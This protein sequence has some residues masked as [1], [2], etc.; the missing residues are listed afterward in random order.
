MNNHPFQP[1]KNDPEW[2]EFCRCHQS[3]LE[4]VATAQRHPAFEGRRNN[5]VC[6][7]P[8][9]GATCLDRGVVSPCGNCQA[10]Q[11]LSAAQPPSAEVHSRELDEFL[12]SDA[13]EQVRATAQPP[14]AN[15]QSERLQAAADSVVAASFM[16]APSSDDVDLRL[17]LS[18]FIKAALITESAAAPDH[19]TAATIRMA[20]ID[21]IDGGNPKHREGFQ[22]EWYLW[23]AQETTANEERLDFCDAV[24][25]RARQL[26]QGKG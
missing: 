20:I 15:G 17:R 3:S 18:K 11:S 6:G 8:L 25:A 10:F 23:S 4:H 24:E 19:F 21:V 1:R 16:T 5:L 7:A 13:A 9:W 2:C 26:A 22:G 14:L 12:S